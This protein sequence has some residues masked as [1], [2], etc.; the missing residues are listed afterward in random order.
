MT[1]ASTLD[2]D[3]EDARMVCALLARYLPNTTVWAYG[4]RTRGRARAASD[5]DLVAHAQPGPSLQVGD[6][7]EAFEESDLPFRVDLFVWDDLPERAR[8]EIE[9]THIALQA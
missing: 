8:A 5:L 2:M 6:L 7:R 1:A 4:S 3:P 9:Q